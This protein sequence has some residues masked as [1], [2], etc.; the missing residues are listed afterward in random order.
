MLC[1]R[2]AYSP[3]V[4]MGTFRELSRPSRADD[5]FKPE[6]RAYPQ[7][8]CENEPSSQN[9]PFAEPIARTIQMPPKHY[10]L[11]ETNPNRAQT[12]DDS[13]SSP[14]IFP[15]AP[16]SLRLP[17]FIS[18]LCTAALTGDATKRHC[19]IKNSQLRARNVPTGTFIFFFTAFLSI[20][21]ASALQSN[22]LPIILPSAL[23]STT[24]SWDALLLLPIRKAA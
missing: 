9:R 5:L 18:V 1:S 4:P 13:S 17:H 10:S 19:G 24:I 16:Q 20:H 14:N 7:G 23:D 21:S 2:S 11:L 22:Q 8:E 12:S 15:G 6:R 3:T